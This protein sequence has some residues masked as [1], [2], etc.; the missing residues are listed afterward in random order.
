MARKKLRFNSSNFEEFNE[1]HEKVIRTRKLGEYRWL[2]RGSDQFASVSD[3]DVFPVHWL[4]FINI[5]T[6]L[7][8]QDESPRREGC[9]N[10]LHFHQ[11]F[12][13]TRS[14]QR[15]PDGI[16]IHPNKA[17]GEIIEKAIL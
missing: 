11:I 4:C 9:Q 16:A 13:R 14:R 17:K 1:F 10:A 2:H 8:S 6:R 12:E 3:L 7:D 5:N 15:D